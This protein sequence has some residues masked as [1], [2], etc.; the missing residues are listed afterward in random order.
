MIRYRTTIDISRPLDAFTVT[1]PSALDTPF[2]REEL[3]NAPDKPYGMNAK[4]TM[5]AH[6]GTHVDAPLHVLEANKGVDRS[7]ITAM[8]G[9]CRVLDMTHVPDLVRI[10]DLEMLDITKGERVILKTRNSVRGFKEW[11]DDF[12]ALDP[13][14]AV[15]LAEK[16]VILVGIDSLSIKQRSVPDNRAHTALLEKGIVIVEGLSLGKVAPGK[17]DLVVLPLRVIDGDGA[18]ARA[19]LLAE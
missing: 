1:Y 12:I 4:L 18:P 16:G 19:V 13:D 14:A 10:T 17:Y 11:Y 5:G 15:W 7:P 8:I 3:R 9:A 6:S 2:V